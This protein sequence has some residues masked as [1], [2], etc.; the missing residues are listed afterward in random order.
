MDGASRW[1]GILA[2]TTGNPNERGRIDGYISFFR[3]QHAGIAAV[4]TREI[5]GMFALEASTS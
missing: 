3:W 5:A 1:S 2:A 4:M